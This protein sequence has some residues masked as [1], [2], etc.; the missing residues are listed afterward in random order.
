M[1]ISTTDTFLEVELRLK[2]RV[3]MQLSDREIQNTLD[4]LKKKKNAGRTETKKKENSKDLESV[5]EVV[6]TIGDTPVVRKDRVEKVKK[7]IES[8]SYD[9]SSDE[10]AKKI[11]G[12]VISDKLD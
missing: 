7:A 3:D 5:K 6:K 8:S 4:S 2:G 10:V 12:R 1:R 9:V 11:I